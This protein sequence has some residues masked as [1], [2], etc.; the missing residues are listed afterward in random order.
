MAATA[1]WS[2]WRRGELDLVLV[3]IG[4]ATAVASQLGDLVESLWKRGVGV[5]D[6]GGVLPGHGGILDRMD[7]MLYAA[8]TLLL[9]LWACGYEVDR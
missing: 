5:K 4:A 1:I 8:P 9:L 2:V 3:G 6:S 7:A